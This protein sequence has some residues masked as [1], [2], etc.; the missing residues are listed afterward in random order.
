M[1]S[2]G[3]IILY[4]WDNQVIRSSQHEFMKG[5]SCLTNLSSFYDKMIHLV[6]EGKAG[7][8]VYCVLVN[9][10]TP[11]PTVFS[12]R[13]WLLMAWTVVQFTG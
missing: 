2:Y 6:D 5:K 4:V 11:F 1:S 9:H 7:D 8:A 10:L 3:V 12:W 13:D